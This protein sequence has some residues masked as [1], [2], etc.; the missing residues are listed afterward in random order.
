MHALGVFYPEACLFL[1][2][3]DGILAAWVRGVCPSG[4]IRIGR[5]GILVSAWLILF[6]LRADFGKIDSDGTAAFRLGAWTPGR[7][8]PVF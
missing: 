3:A 6:A 5:A 7:A 1:F 4:C 8:V 2:S